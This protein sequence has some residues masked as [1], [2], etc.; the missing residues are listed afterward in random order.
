MTG[1][2]FYT[3]VYVCL[4]LLDKYSLYWGCDSAVPLIQ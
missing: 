3:L 1:H 4:C 2:I